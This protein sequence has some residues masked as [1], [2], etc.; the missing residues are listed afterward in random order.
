[1]V[2]YLLQYGSIPNV[3][4]KWNRGNFQTTMNVTQNE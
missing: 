4:E 3:C 2:K 1:M